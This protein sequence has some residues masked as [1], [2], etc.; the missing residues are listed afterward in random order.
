MKF[1]R[2]FQNCNMKKQGQRANKCVFHITISHI[3]TQYKL[4]P[5]FLPH[6]LP[7]FIPSF[8]PSCHSFLSPCLSSFLLTE[9]DTKNDK[10]CLRK[11][12]Q[13]FEVGQTDGWMNR[14]SNMKR[15][16]HATKNVSPILLPSHP[17]KENQG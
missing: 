7:L 8:L 16:V 15:R 13:N 6:S 17:F 12:V 10:F 4:L 3:T 2:N 5:S 9:Q 1:L 14:Q 11:K